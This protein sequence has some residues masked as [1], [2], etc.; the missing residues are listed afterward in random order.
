MFWI[1]DINECTSSPRAGCLPVGVA[2]CVNYVPGYQCACNPGY[3]LND[4]DHTCKG[5]KYKY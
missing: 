2:T 3:V 5:K 1:I 4:D